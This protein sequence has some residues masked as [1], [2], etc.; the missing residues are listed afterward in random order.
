MGVHSRLIVPTVLAIGAAGTLSWA[1][2][3]LDIGTVLADPETYQSQVV[4]VSGVVVNHKLR[5]SGANRCYQSFTVKDETG[6]IHAVHRANCSGAKNAL[7]N[8][9]LV[10]VDGRFEWAPGQGGLLKVQSV[11]VKV[12]PSAQ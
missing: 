1:S 6:S 12:V 4:R 9:D 10:T 5:R 11:V 3:M 2:A 8:R 7:R